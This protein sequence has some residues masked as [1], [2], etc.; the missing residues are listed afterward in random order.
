MGQRQRRQDPHDIFPARAEHFIPVNRLER[1]RA[2]WI[3]VRVKKTR[4][5]KKLEPRSDS[6]GTDKG[7]RSRISVGHL[8]FVHQLTSESAS[9]APAPPRIASAGQSMPRGTVMVFQC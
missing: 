9:R 8:R 7:S 4:Q 5:N 3:P 1:F 6:I 2:K